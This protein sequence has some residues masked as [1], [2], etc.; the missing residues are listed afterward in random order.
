MTKGRDN[1]AERLGDVLELIQSRG[2]HGLLSV[3]R[4]EAGRFEEGEIYFDGGKPVYARCGNMSGKEALSWLSSWRQIYFSFKKNAPRPRLFTEMPPAISPLP[5]SSPQSGQKAVRESSSEYKKAPVNS[6]SGFSYSDPGSI[7]PQR[8]RVDQDVLSL[9]LTRPQ[10]S[11]Y[12]LVDGH[13]TLVDLARCVNK[14]IVDV[15]QLLAELQE[16]GLVSL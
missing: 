2:Q 8:L 11:I 12:L 13:R 10:R 5:P 7:V 9:P 15:I 14:N 16:H 6:G 1:P 3:E 4:F